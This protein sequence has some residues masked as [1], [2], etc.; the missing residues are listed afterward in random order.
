MCE[1]VFSSV[2]F[3]LLCVCVCV[4]VVFC[5]CFVFVSM[6]HAVDVL[7]YYC[8]RAHVCDAPDSILHGVV[9]LWFRIDVFGSEGMGGG[10]CF[11]FGSSRF[12]VCKERHCSNALSYRAVLPCYSF[13]RRRASAPRWI[14]PWRRVLTTIWL[15]STAPWWLRML[16]S[17]SSNQRATSCHH[18]V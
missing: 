17:T 11:L 14:S 9:A 3:L 13:R 16:R 8:V 18:F 2:C 6:L 12:P 4:C 7:V 1:C 10:V 5:F 15:I